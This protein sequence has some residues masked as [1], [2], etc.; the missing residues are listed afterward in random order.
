MSLTIATAMVEFTL[1]KG[2]KSEEVA[3]GEE[4]KPK[5]IRLFGFDIYPSLQYQHSEV[6]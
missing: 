5:P 1:S 6:D 2:T 3:A 4:I